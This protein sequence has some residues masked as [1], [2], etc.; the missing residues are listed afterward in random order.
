M[1][2]ANTD[3]YDIEY[4]EPKNRPNLDLM[5]NE[6]IKSFLLLKSRCSALVKLGKDFSDIRIGYNT[7]DSYNNMMKIFK[8]Y[9]SVSNQGNEKSKTIVFLS[10]P[11]TLISLDDYYYLD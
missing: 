3:F 4:Y 7:W 6:Q 2:T 1:M 9:H 8:E 11:A 10:Y 5:T